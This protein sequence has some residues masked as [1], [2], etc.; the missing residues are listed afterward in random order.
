[1]RKSSAARASAAAKEEKSLALW[2]AELKKEPEGGADLTGVRPPEAAAVA[3]PAEGVGHLDEAEPSRA[4]DDGPNPHAQ[5]RPHDEDEALQAPTSANDETNVPQV[6]SGP[7]EEMKAPQVPIGPR[8]EMKAPPRPAAAGVA[9]PRPVVNAFPGG[10]G[11]E[12]AREGTGVTAADVARPRPQP[13]A[14]P[15]PAGGS[16][17]DVAVEAGRM[18][19]QPA[20]RTVV[21][22]T[23]RPVAA[24]V[25]TRP[26]AA[27]AKPGVAGSKSSGRVTAPETP[28]VS[29]H[30]SRP[31]PNVLLTV[32][33]VLAIVGA[34]VVLVLLYAKASHTRTQGQNTKAFTTSA[35]SAPEKPQGTKH[36]GAPQATTKPGRRPSPSLTTAV[37]P[38]TRPQATAKADTAVR[39]VPV[40]ATPGRTTTSPAAVHVTFEAESYTVNH[41]TENSFPTHASGEETVGHTAAGDWV[42]YANRSMAGVHSVVLRCTAGKGGASV[43]IR[44]SSAS[45][46]LLGTASLPET[47][48]FDTF[49]SVT[50]RLTASSSGPLFI[51]FLGPTAADLD[52]VTL[53]S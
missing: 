10:D 1:M 32:P 28:T 22:A 23:T 42:G 53:S 35:G 34:V 48:D 9:R 20:A 33:F 36:L 51:A 8:E 31:R 50:V 38:A 24:E 43:Q 26:A 2:L 44:A 49:E 46:P 29:S 52:T 11:A 37:R 14:K 47:P 6:P 15:L 41:G 21:A 19:R 16:S 17:D 18:A 25:R 30:P 40:Q 12:V 4:G 45:G 5:A 27:P 3:E 13:L 7:R 39:P